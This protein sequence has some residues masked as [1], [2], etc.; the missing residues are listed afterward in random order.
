MKNSEA[1]FDCCNPYIRGSYKHNTICPWTLKTLKCCFILS[2]SPRWPCSWAVGSKDRA[3]DE[4]KSCI[5]GLSWLSVSAGHPRTIVSV[6]SPLNCLPVL[7]FALKLHWKVF[8]LNVL[9][10][11]TTSISPSLL[12]VILH[13]C[14]RVDRK[15]LCFTFY[16]D[17][18]LCCTLTPQTNS[19]YS[20][21][22][23]TQLLFVTLQRLWYCAT[24]LFVS[25]VFFVS[26]LVAVGV[27]GGEPHTNS[28]TSSSMADGWRLKRIYCFN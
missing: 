12:N 28:A 3:A 5:G 15:A 23:K 21:T 17:L 2:L 6:L 22:E 9:L 4:W 27:W 11:N 8:L 7:A 16:F 18:Q 25:Q 1:S 10:Q 19:K 14:I 24:P 13:L 26:G 20:S